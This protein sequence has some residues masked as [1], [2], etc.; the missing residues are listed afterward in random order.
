[1]MVCVSGKVIKKI[2]LLAAF[3]FSLSCFA[4][5]INITVV[6]NN[7]A[8]DE[9]L[10]TAWGISYF[11]EGLEENILFD[12]GG[13]GAI[14]LGNMEKLGINP[15]EI[16]TVV[17]SHIH[18]DHIGGVQHLLQTNSQVTVYFPE[19]FP[20]SFKNKL[21]SLCKETVPVHKPL[22][23]CRKVWSTGE[24]G[25]WIKE[26]SLIIDTQKGLIVITGCAHPG[27]VNIVK[28]AKSY[29]KKDVYLILG[30]FHLMAYNENQVKKIIK[31]LK[32]L[33]IEKVGPSH[34]TGGRPIEL[35]REAWGGDFIEL[36]CGAKLNLVRDNPPE[37]D[38]NHP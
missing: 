19:S 28:F 37:A 8:Y 4:E 25:S 5:E 32:E 30:G 18:A 15:M 20:E 1:M 16:D 22:K 7:V 23:I 3:L 35:F 24:L 11:I 17:L 6:Y 26:Q 31:D 29:L 38:V 2:I 34:C 12:T 14:L 33:G 13:D 27:I 36:G 21:K 10:T 9:N